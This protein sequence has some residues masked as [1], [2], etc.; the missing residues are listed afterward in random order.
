MTPAQRWMILGGAVVVVV[1]LGVFIFSG[2]GL[3]LPRPSSLKEWS[4][5]QAERASRSAK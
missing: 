4:R 5:A 1:I 3:R 2:R